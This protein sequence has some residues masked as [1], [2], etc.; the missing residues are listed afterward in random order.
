M[1]LLGEGRGDKLFE[2]REE[3]R[4]G[5]SS[6]LAFAKDCSNPAKIG[7]YL[8]DIGRMSVEDGMRI[9]LGCGSMGND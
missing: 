3:G 7:L 2:E 6:T 5:L 8:A 1:E 9:A 4:P